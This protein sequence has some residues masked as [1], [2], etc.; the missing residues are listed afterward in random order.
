MATFDPFQKLRVVDIARQLG[1]HPFD[2]VRIL[3]VKDVFHPSLRFEAADLEKVRSYGGVET[4]WGPD[5]KVEDDPIRARGILRSIVRELVCRRL[6]GDRTTRSD[7]IYRGMD[8]EDESIAR[9]A[10]NHLLQEHLLRTL[11]TPMGNHVS[12]VPEQVPVMESLAEG[13]AMPAG[14]AALWLV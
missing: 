12:I 8:P 1:I 14:L 10:L 5:R 6:I 7:N 4:W 13:R 11:S 9:K 3:T 2:V